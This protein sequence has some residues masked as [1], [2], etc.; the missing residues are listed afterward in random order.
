M[1]KHTPKTET[2]VL[3]LPFLQDEYRMK[4]LQ[5]DKDDL[6]KRLNGLLTDRENL[7]VVFQTSLPIC[8]QAKIVLM[9]NLIITYNFKEDLVSV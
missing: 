5:Q 7:E 9:L 3:K 1:Y 6:Y 2:S 4:G 8:F